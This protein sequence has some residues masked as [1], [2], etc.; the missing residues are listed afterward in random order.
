M[1]LGALAGDSYYGAGAVS[2]SE[3]NCFDIKV[4]DICFAC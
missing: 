4:L 2:P 3:A 1:V